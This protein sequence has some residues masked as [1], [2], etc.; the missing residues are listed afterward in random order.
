MLVGKHTKKISSS[1]RF[2]GETEKCKSKETWDRESCSLPNLVSGI[3]KVGHFKKESSSKHNFL[4][5]GS[6]HHNA[7]SCW[8]RMLPQGEHVKN[9]CNLP[10]TFLSFSK[11][12]GMTL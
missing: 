7:T 2:R 4:L 9:C 6:V 5:V 10:Y 8:I 3:E 11:Y 12:F 1:C